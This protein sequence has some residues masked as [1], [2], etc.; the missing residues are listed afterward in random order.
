MCEIDCSKE[1]ATRDGLKVT[2]LH[3]LTE[4]LDSGETLIGVAQYPNGVRV[5]CQ[6]HSHGCYLENAARHSQD[7]IEVQVA[8]EKWINIY[9]DHG[10]YDSQEAANEHAGSG[11]IACIPVRFSE[12]E[13][14]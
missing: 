10:K 13:G 11:R 7:L 9:N 1:Y 6:W 4:P 5:R 3:Q 8:H 12:G 14:L 2:D